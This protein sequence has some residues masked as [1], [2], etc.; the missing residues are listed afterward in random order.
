VKAVYIRTDGKLEYGKTYTVTRFDYSCGNN[1]VVLSDVF[2]L[3][4]AAAFEF[5]GD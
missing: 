3:Y 1:R 5:E 4:D 2:G